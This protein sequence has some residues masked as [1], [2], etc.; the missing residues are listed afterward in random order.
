MNLVDPLTHTVLRPVHGATRSSTIAAR[1]C[2]AIILGVFPDGHQIPSESSLTQ[3]FNAAPMTI[4]EALTSLR[5]EGLIV[6]R[7][8]R[9]GGSFVAD[10]AGATLTTVPESSTILDASEVAHHVSA[11][12]GCAAALA[13]KRASAADVRELITH[14]ERHEK[15][16]AN[17]PSAL[18]QAQAASQVSIQIARL[19]QSTRLTREIIAAQVEWMPWATG[20]P[21][22]LR[23]L[24]EAVGGGDTR[25]A[26]EAVDEYF[27]AQLR[28]LTVLKA[29]SAAPGRTGATGGAE[30]AA[31]RLAEIL[32]E[33]RDAVNSVAESV[34]DPRFGDSLVTACASS[35][36]SCPNL[37]GVGF[38]A[39]PESGRELVEWFVRDAPRTTAGATD[40]M[41]RR[42]ALDLSASAPGDAGYRG[43]TWYTLPAAVGHSTVVGPY[44][45]DLCGDDYT[46]TISVPSVRDGIF[47][48]VFVGDLSVNTIERELLP[49][50]ATSGKHLAVVN[51][52]G[53]VTVSTDPFA[54][55]GALLSEADCTAVA[56]ADPFP[57][58]VVSRG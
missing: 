57:Y 31:C 50:L 9:S 54:P 24:A 47:A 48:G 23:A 6:T 30:E 18:A 7:R 4:R 14:V 56:A 22:S 52:E 32:S 29:G 45:D 46:L 38:A 53:R 10:T 5:K 26:Q 40:H 16:A 13:A 55:V 11:L 28:E 34:P 35:L 49:L 1:L 2:D 3:L 19:S 43:F 8:G 36:E 39:S 25:A 27:A 15:A 21:E 12:T 37:S 58:Q 42:R 51:G 17:R 33:A 20:A 41:V 44:V